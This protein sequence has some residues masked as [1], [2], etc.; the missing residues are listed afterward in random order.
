MS[1]STTMRTTPA[2]NCDRRTFVTPPRAVR[3][4]A[5]AACASVAPAMSTTTRCGDVSTK[6]CTVTGCPTWMLT[7]AEPPSVA[8]PP[9]GATRTAVTAPRAGAA[10]SRA[11]R[12]AAGAVVGAAVVGA[13]VGAAVGADG[14]GAACSAAAAVIRV[15]TPL[16]C[17]SLQLNR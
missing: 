8:V 11:L 2:R 3:S 13:A 7:S 17:S 16:I 5:R 10:A 14:V 12:N 1:S 15:P 6:S 9:V 4:Y